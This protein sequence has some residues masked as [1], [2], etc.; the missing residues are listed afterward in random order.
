MNYLCCINRQSS[1][2]INWGQKIIR[3]EASGMLYSN[4]VQILYKGVLC[5]FTHLSGLDVHL[6][7]TQPIVKLI[8]LQIPHCIDSEFFCT[9][10]NIHHVIKMFQ[11]EVAGVNAIYS[12]YYAHMLLYDDSILRKFMKLHLSI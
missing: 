6:L 5:C 8:T 10:L 4:G 9:S 1:I 7:E 3:M 11:T 2:K 12:L